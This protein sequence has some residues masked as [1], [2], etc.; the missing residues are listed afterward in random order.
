MKT[1]TLAA[2]GTIASSAA[3]AG[4]LVYTA[5]VATTMEE[6]AMMGGSGAWLI[7]LVIL[8]VLALALTSSNGSQ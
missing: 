7:P 4:A 2:L 5:P 1:F 3:S 6:P 8:A